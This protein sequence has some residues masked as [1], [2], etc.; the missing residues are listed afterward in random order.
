MILLHL[1]E[2]ARKSLTKISEQTEIPLTTVYDIVNRLKDKDIIHRYVPMIDFAKIGFSVRMSIALKADN[3]RDLLGFLISNA[4][5]NS[6]HKVT[7]DYDFLA[8][9]V[10]QN[11]SDYEMFKEEIERFKLLKL[12]EH[13]II[14]EVKREGFSA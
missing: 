7:G 12:R 5:I 6:V 10:F 4:N 14:E 1:R 8:D 11:M 13:H 3:K 9:A 2:D